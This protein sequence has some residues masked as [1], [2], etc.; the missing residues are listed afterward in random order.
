MTARPLPQ[1]ISGITVYTQPK[2]TSV[3]I[4]PITRRELQMPR[5]ILF[6]RIAFTLV[7]LPWLT[8]ATAP[9]LAEAPDLE[10]ILRNPVIGNYKGYAE[11]KMG[12]YENARA[13]WQALENKGN[14]QASFNLGIL[15]ED[16]LGVAQDN[17]QAL[18]HY[19]KSAQAGSSKAQYR[20]GLLYSAGVKTPK[21]DAKADQWLAAAAAQGD[22]D[23]IALLEQRKDAAQNQ[24][25]SDY[26]SAEALHAAGQH[27]Q[28]FAIWRQLADSGDNRSVTRLAWMYETGQGTA[29]DLDTAARLFRQ[30][31]EAGD[32]E[33]QYALAV[34]LQTGQGQ[35]RDT[36]AAQRWLQRAAAQGYGPAIEAQRAD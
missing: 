20:L 18:Y 8:L 13:I 14:A 6:K 32:P 1:H 7:I 29:R 4:R 36:A 17:G 12:H 31:A 5:G 19:E 24:R 35:P 30:S 26:F 16:G 23:A 34:M 22:E 27:Q 28:A 33:A 10:E 3:H 25:D 2:S 15:Y 11:F 9:A 21:D